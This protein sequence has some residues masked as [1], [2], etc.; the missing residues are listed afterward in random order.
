MDTVLFQI[1]I[2]SHQS[3][4]IY[5]RMYIFIS[6]GLTPEFEMAGGGGGEPTTLDTTYDHKSCRSP[7]E[8]N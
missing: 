7:L 2:Y 8:L 1:C 6:P 5:T 4:N 3:Y